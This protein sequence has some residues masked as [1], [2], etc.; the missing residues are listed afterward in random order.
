[1]KRPTALCLV[2]ATCLALPATVLAQ[3][4][5]RDAAGRMVYS[6]VPPPPSVS[7]DS[8]VRAPGRAPGE[9]RPAE[10]AP[11]QKAEG[12][13][14]KAVAAAVAAPTP[15]EAFQKRR[16]AQQKA[17]AEQATKDRE[18]Q[19]RQAHCNE[20]RN[21]ATALQQGMRVAVA[22]PDGSM[23]RLDGDRRQAEVNKTNA[24]LEQHCS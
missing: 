2:A 22:T 19:Q 12:A 7:A 21:Y 5:W 23:E 6:D 24:S 17:E 14:A 10:T 8:I 4:Q 9:Y 18:A 11:P 15:E 20:L 1:M 13:P 3:W 16:A